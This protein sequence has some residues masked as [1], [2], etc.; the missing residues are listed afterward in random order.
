MLS[1]SLGIL[2]PH[3]HRVQSLKLT[4]TLV[5]ALEIALDIAILCWSAS[6]STYLSILDITLDIALGWTWVSLP[7][8]KTSC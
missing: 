5:T 8:K 2:L 7:T 1:S 3:V 4:N 6:V